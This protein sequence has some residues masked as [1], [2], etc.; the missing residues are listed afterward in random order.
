MN[1]IPS[2]SKN[3]SFNSNQQLLWQYYYWPPNACIK[4]SNW[5]FG[6]LRCDPQSNARCLESTIGQIPP[7]L[8][9]TTSC[10]ESEQEKKVHPFCEEP[11]QEKCTLQTH[12]F[13]SMKIC[14][15]IPDFFL[16]HTFPS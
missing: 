10:E 6:G 16:L 11:E 1:M 12:D 2:N 13:L 7:K 5:D 8:S 3:T 14:C 15:K 4:A 9:A